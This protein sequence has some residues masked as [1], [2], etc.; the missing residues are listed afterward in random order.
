MK[1]IIAL[2]GISGVGK[3]YRRTHDPKLVDLPYLDIADIYAQTPGISMPQALL[4]LVQTAGKLLEE[5]DTIILEA[6]FKPR[7]GQRRGLEWYFSDCGIEIEYIEL[8][9]PIS[10]CR[11]R[12]LA[13][14]DERDDEQWH[15]YIEAR[16]RLLDLEERLPM[17]KISTKEPTSWWGM[18]LGKE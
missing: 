18:V 17:S 3:T 9:A 4:D 5:H 10:V 6:Y 1:K 8:E 12:I 7:S 13:Q 2:S 11:E 14:A 15:R 16:L